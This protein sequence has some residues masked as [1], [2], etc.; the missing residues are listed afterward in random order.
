MYNCSCISP[1]MTLPIQLATTWYQSLFLPMHLAEA[2]C[3]FWV[4]PMQTD[5]S[6]CSYQPGYLK[7]HII[8]LILL[9]LATPFFNSPRLFLFSISF[10]F[11]TWT[12]CWNM[13]THK[14]EDQTEMQVHRSTTQWMNSE[15][16]KY[17][18]LIVIWLIYFYIVLC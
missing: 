3:Q 1:C 4:L 7:S 11:V 6:L 16:I 8:L 14:N 15:L 9:C 5:I 2:W 13:S 18:L 10:I 12:H 17:T